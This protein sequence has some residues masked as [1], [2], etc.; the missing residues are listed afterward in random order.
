ME[1]LLFI[2]IGI[3]L[4]SCNKDSE[5]PLEA[6]KR[7]FISSFESVDDFKNFYITPQGHLGTTFHE[8]SDSIVYSGEFWG[9]KA[10]FG[11]WIN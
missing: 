1:R 10:T 2:L 9:P 6:D 7:E 5:V 11:F 4:I 3:L 8:L